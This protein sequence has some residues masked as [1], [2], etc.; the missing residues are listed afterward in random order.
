MVP[1]LEAAFAEHTRAEIMD[2]MIAVDIPVAPH[3]DF[4]A[5][6]DDRQVWDNDYIVKTADGRMH[7]GVGAK[8]HE[9]PAQV[10]GPPP[11]LGQHTREILV[12]AG[13]SGSDIDGLL[14]SGVVEEHTADD[15]P[16]K[17]KSRL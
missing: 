3:N 13:Y 4:E 5:L 2:M 7:V 16:A 1:I 11:A 17:A 14:G 12:E 10:Q 8:F 9:T 15:K 6:L